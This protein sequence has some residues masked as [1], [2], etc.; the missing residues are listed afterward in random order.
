M[1]TRSIVEL[2]GGRI[3]ARSEG[4][5]RG[6]E[7]Q[8]WL[9]LLPPLEKPDVALINRVMPGMDGYK[10]ARRLCS[11]A[12]LKKTARVAITGY[13]RPEDIQRAREAKFHDHWVKPVDME[14]LKRVL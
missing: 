9:P 12:D 1:V 5:G 7:F 2:H 6:S 4:P 3:E 11:S 14:T 10:V 13:G 8:I